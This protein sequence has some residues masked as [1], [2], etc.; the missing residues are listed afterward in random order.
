M[1]SIQISNFA[2]WIVIRTYVPFELRIKA[3]RYRV[4]TLEYPLE[5]WT[6]GERYEI[7]YSSNFDNTKRSYR[8]PFSISISLIYHRSTLLINF[9]FNS[10]TDNKLLLSLCQ[11]FLHW[12]SMFLAFARSLEKRIWGC[13][14]RL[15]AKHSFMLLKL[16][17]FLSTNTI[18][19][20]Y[21]HW[22]WIAF[23]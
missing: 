19:I 6:T 18:D 11:M 2:I 15:N 1:R 22:A 23:K 17:A 20:I 16:N 13:G 4:E 14:I 7:Q 9:L 5:K 3:C 12:G 10:L 21:R 8:I